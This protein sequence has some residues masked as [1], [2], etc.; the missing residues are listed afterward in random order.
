MNFI[1]IYVNLMRITLIILTI[2]HIF[3]H[4]FKKIKSTVLVFILTFL[5]V[6]L[7]KVFYIKI[8]SL[9]SILYFTAI[10]MSIYL[11]SELKFYDKYSWWDRAIHFMFGIV[12][13]SFGIVIASKMSVAGKFSM[14]FFSFTLSTT[15]HALWEVAEYLVDCIAHTDHQRWQKNYSTINHVSEKAIQPAGLVDTMNDIIICMISTIIA[16]MVWWFIL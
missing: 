5:P 4:D 13:V 11:G 8:D 10:F 12:F 2:Y 3:K 7:E 15:L 14:L 1:D 16:C 6:F 9:G